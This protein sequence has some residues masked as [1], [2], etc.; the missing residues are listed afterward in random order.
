MPP[1]YLDHNASTPPAPEVVEAM[2]PWL[3]TSHANPHA[4]HL[5]GRM[6]AAAVDIA[7]EQ[8]GALI[9]GDPHDLVI[10]SG[11]TESNNLALQGL[12]NGKASGF[13][14]WHSAI[15]HK[16][17]VEV[18]RH[19]AA[20]GLHVQQLPV[21]S[22][23]NLRVDILRDALA[24]ESNVRPV[25]SVMHANNEIGTVQPISELRQLIA[26]ASGILH[27]DASQSAGRL[28]I[29]VESL[30]VDLLSMSAHKLYGPAGI[31]A[32][33]VAPHIRPLLRPIFFGGGQQDGLRPGTLPVFLAV[34]FGAACALAQR[35]MVQDGEKAEVVAKIFCE[36]LQSLGVKFDVLG[37][38]RHHLPGLRSL[39]LEDIDGDDLVI[40]LAHFLSFSTGSACSAGEL[41]GSHVLSAIGLTSDEARSV[42]RIGFGRSSTVT[43]AC[44]AAE[45]LDQ[46]VKSCRLATER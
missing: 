31:G 20:S 30:G 40:R 4:E 9:A 5:A 28:P 43:D 38:P 36:R 37:D 33:Y 1:L 8:I 15:E 3:G 14:L 25:L 39:R 26:P 16:S 7:L 11:A 45:V 35:R 21:N 24:S 22:F 19:L 42:I 23:G 13:K 27:V 18:A 41:R 46:A 10:T 17:V 6:A 29:N 12:L 44:N 2:L 34:G 32:L